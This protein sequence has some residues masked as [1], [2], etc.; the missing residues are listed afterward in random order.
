MEQCV[1]DTS[2][3][4]REQCMV[5]VHKYVCTLYKLGTTRVAIKIGTL[6]RL[7]GELVMIDIMV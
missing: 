3:L 7:Y 1:H 5:F 2:K 6:I 4:I